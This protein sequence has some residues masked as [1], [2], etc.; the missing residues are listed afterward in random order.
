M[1]QRA[2]EN[3][4]DLKRL[5]KENGLLWRRNYDLASELDKNGVERPEHRPD[6]TAYFQEDIP[7]G[8]QNERK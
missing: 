5:R 3:R 7:D 6:W 2:K 4:E 8:K 1:Q